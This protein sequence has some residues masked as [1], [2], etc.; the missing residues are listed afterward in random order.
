MTQTPLAA[1]LIDADGVAISGTYGRAHRTGLWPVVKA[2][3]DI[4]DFP[5]VASLRGRLQSSWLSLNLQ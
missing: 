5:L 3:E 2:A 4:F 1:P